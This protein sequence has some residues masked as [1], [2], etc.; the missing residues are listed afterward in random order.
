MQGNATSGG[1]ENVYHC[2]VTLF[3][4]ANHM[5]V[6]PQMAGVTWNN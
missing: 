6:S 3:T 2:M 4:Y 5:F 1:G